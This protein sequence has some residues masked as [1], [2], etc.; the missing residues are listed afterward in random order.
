MAKTKEEKMGKITGMKIIAIILFVMLATQIATG[1]A[2]IAFDLHYWLG[3]AIGVTIV[4]H[5]V[6][7]WGWIRTNIFGIKPKA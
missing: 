7:N 4:I 6:V 2:G 5:L 3:I 1:L